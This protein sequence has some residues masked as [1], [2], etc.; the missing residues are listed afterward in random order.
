MLLIYCTISIC[1]VLIY[2]SNHGKSFMDNEWT[3]QIFLVTSNFTTVIKFRNS[4]E[5]PILYQISFFSKQ[6]QRRSMQT[7]TRSDSWIGV[8][9]WKKTPIKSCYSLS[10]ANSICHKICIQRCCALFW[11][12]I[13]LSGFLVFIYLPIF[14]KVA[15]LLL[16]S[17]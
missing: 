12:I 2:I 8:L 5:A 17:I 7:V 3:M 9:S 6:T 4:C 13:I 16:S 1:C 10:D 11:Y 14:F 15:L